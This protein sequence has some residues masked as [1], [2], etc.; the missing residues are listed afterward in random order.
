M[1]IEGSIIEMLASLDYN[2][3]TCSSN[4]TIG[5]SDLHHPNL[6]LTF[7]RSTTHL[8]LFHAPVFKQ[9]LTLFSFIFCD[10]RQV[11]PGILPPLSLPHTPRVQPFTLPLSLPRPSIFA[12]VGRSEP[13]SRVLL[14]LLPAHLL[15]YF[16]YRHWQW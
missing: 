9:T 10:S 1:P 11:K 3:I 7:I 12:E 14:S 4:Q 5:C 2:K 13:G 16:Q 15:T 8:V 6:F